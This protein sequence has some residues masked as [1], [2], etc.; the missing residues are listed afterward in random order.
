MGLGDE[1][2]ALG[3]AEQIF[4]DTGKPVAICREGGYAREHAAWNGNPAVDM[5]STK[6]ILDGGGCR[7]YIH[8]WEGRRAVFNL[9]YR[10]HA[11]KIWL[12]D[13]EQLFAASMAPSGRFCVVAPFLK[14]AASPNKDWGQENWEA[15]IDGLPLPVLQLLPTKDTPVIKG[16]RG[17]YTPS[18]RQAAAV[19]ARADFVMCNEGGTHHMAASM[20]VRAVVIFG[21]FVPPLVTG[22]P[23]HINIAVE[24]PEGFCGNFDP[25]KHCQNALALVTPSMVKSAVEGL[26]HD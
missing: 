21:A 14:D 10:P 19:I 9:D 2:M 22:Y 26:L 20:G 24:T 15:V 4:K 1:I 5:F 6:K 7:P 13:E 12:T 17:L 16:A 25:C 3:R 11:G 18:F 8:R 23:E